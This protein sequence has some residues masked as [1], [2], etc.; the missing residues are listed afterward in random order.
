MAYRLAENIQV[1]KESWGLIFYS[2]TRHKIL[3]IRSA[4]WL[5][6]RH[7]DGN[8]TFANIINE[9]STRTGIPAKLIENA[10]RKPIDNL[11]TNG[12]VNDKLR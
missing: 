5:Y 7:F 12:M 11:L 10:I 9:S 8:W 3:F 2:Q 6:P 4:D 1:R